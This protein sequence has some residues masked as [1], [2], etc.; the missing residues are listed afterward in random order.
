MILKLHNYKIISLLILVMTFYT[1]G[2]YAQCAGSN[3]SIT[4]CDVPDISSQNVDLFSKLGPMA[5]PGGTWTDANLSGGLNTTTGV[6]NVQLIKKSGVYSYVYTSNVGCAINTASVTV[7]VGGYAGVSSPNVSTCDDVTSYNLF[8]GF[9]GSELRPHSNGIW[10]DDKTG[11]I[12]GNL[13]NAQSVGLGTH[14]Y[15]YTMKAIGTCSAKSSTV[16]VSIF[17]APRPGNGS[18]LLLCSTDNLGLYADLDLNT[19]VTGADP[20]GVWSESGTTELSDANDTRINVQN[21]YNTLGAGIY[22]FNYTVFPTNPICEPK[23]STVTIVIEEQLDLTGASLVI[24]SDICENEIT[25]ATYNA[26]LTKGIKNVPNGLYKVEYTISGVAGTTTLSTEA[27]FIN[28][29]L[30]FPISSIHYQEVGNYTVTINDVRDVNSLGACPSNVT[31]TDVLHVYPL[32]KINLATLTINPVCKGVDAVTTISGDTNL[33]NG[34]YRIQYNLSGKNTATNQQALF[35]VAGGAA[36]FTI[37]ASLIP[38]EGNTTI[39]ITNI[40]NLTTGCTNTSTLSK[41]FV[42][43]TLTDLSAL[44]IDITNVCQG[45]PLP[46]KLSG[47]GF[48]TSITLNYRLTGANTTNQSVVLAVTSGNTSFTIPAS[49]VANSGATSFVIIDIIDNTG[50]CRST[51]TN[52]TKNFTINSIPNLPIT[53]NP[54]YCKEEKKTI[55]DLIPKGGQYQWF[56]SA[57]STTILNASSLLKTGSYFVKEVNAVTGCESGR[58]ESI[59]V[60]N[61]VTAPTLN[62]DGQNL[63]GL[64]N[65][66]IEDL[67]AKT[68]NN[69]NLQWYDAS[70][71]GNLIN[72]STVLIDGKTYYGF[73]YSPLTNC[74]SEAL[75]VTVSLSNCDETPG[76]FIPDGF[77]PNGDAVNN[78]FRIPDIEYIYPNYTLEIYNR[79]GNLMF[80]GNKQKPEWDGKTSDA[81]LAIDGFA[82]NGVY[83]YVITFNKGNKMPKQGRLYLN[84]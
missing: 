13:L 18:A 54:T 14:S 83:F 21:I 26:V 72:D 12:V 65:P 58:S 75:V 44:T 52:G 36:T 3:A 31:I 68:T 60:I 45:Q 10:T 40:T 29:T 82:P 43:K 46:V 39:S 5:I 23:V 41:E 67:S 16:N 20:D 76:F 7:T 84:R 37:P 30:S 78:T 73:E 70:V 4:V 47:L 62:T 17:R 59:V 48:F 2:F 53:T 24:N 63:C 6:L 35:T 1:T 81:S 57:T 28:G 33:S 49:F 25:T 11:A 27:N 55:G 61:E 19:K 50:G 77:S 38:V 34:N 42:V 51:I 56:D 71:N 8:Q 9:N 69:G 79:Y 80:R 15:T 64:D 32:P 66:K 74:F 22:R